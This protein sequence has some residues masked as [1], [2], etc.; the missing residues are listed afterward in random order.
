MLEPPPFF[1][2]TSIGQVVK[3]FPKPSQICVAQAGVAVDLPW[4]EFVPMAYQVFGGAS[5]SHLDQ[6]AKELDV[7]ASHL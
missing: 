4:G 2:A 6:P 5:E 7:D 1:W 3:P